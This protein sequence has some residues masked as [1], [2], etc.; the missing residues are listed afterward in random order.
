MIKQ[1]TETLYFSIVNSFR[2]IIVDKLYKQS[3]I[4]VLVGSIRGKY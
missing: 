2:W 3:K 4:P 1:E